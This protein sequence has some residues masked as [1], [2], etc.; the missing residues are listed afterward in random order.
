MAEQTKPERAIS[1]G[2]VSVRQLLNRIRYLLDQWCNGIC[3]MKQTRRMAGRVEVI[4]A[5][6]PMGRF[7]VHLS[8]L[9]VPDKFPHQES[10]YGLEQ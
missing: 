4:K 5:A 7:R 10:L 9:Q 8:S 6:L 1:W 3:F 2:Q